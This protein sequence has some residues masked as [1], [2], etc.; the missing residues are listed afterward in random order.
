[1]SKKKKSRNA[2][3]KAARAVATAS[4]DSKETLSELHASEEPG[5]GRLEELEPSNGSADAESKHRVER[6][7]NYASGNSKPVDFKSTESEPNANALA[8]SKRKPSPTPTPAATA[9]PTPKT[10]KK[11]GSGLVYLLFFLSGL[12]SLIYQVVWTRELVLVFGGTTFATSTVLAIFMGG[13][14]LGSYLA[15]RYTDRIERPLRIYGILEG[16]IGGWALIAPILFAAV[17]PVY[18][19]VWQHTHASLLA[20]SLLR[21]AA[22]CLILLVPTTCMGAT[23]PILAK[24]VTSALETVGKQVGRLYALNTFGAICGALLG[25]FILLPQCGLTLATIIAAAINFLLTATAMLQ[26][27]QKQLPNESNELNESD[28]LKE[29]EAAKPSTAPAGNRQDSAAGGTAITSRLSLAAKIVMT[30]FAASGAVAMIYEVCWT[31]ALLMIIGSST[32]AFTVMLSTFLIGIFLGSIVISRYAD[33]AKS[34][35]FWFAILQMTLGVVSLICIR[36]FDRVPFWNL[37]INQHFMRSVTVNMLVRFLLAGVVLIPITTCLGAIFPV[38]VRVCTVSL[39]TVGRSIGTL[40]AANTVGAIVGAFGAGFV[41]LPLF[42][43][44]KTLLWSAFANFLL[45]AALIS[46]SEKRKPLVNIA[47]AVAACGFGAFLYFNPNAWNHNSLIVAQAD[48][49]I[50]RSGTINTKSFEKWQ[51]EQLNTHT[52]VFWKDGSCSNV[53]VLKYGPKTSLLTNGHVDAS[54]GQDTNVQSFVSML[55]LMLK[56]DAKDIAVVGWGSGQTVGASLLFPIRECDAIE[57]EPAVIKASKWFHH[58]NYKAEEDPRVHIEYN[59]GRNF[60]L[61]TN[62]LYDLVISEPSNPWQSGVCNLF[63]REYFHICHK[64][65]K[66]GGMFSLWLQTSEV[67]PED[68]SAVLSAVNKEYPHAVAFLPSLGNIVIWHPTIQSLST[69]TTSRSNLKMQE[70]KKSCGMRTLSLPNRCFH[71]LS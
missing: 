56:P 21:F 44:E 51:Q 3:K 9:R 1:M 50:L 39:A 8:E 5:S 17:T 68:I 28:D 49:R 26:K 70:S 10:Q 45:G 55:P 41:L 7:H 46:V 12:S 31:R 16:I 47:A 38:V 14:A 61:A 24:F 69:S 40:Y 6:P 53:A 27:Q 25:G 18:A 30:A 42:G 19:V 57:L 58:L 34:P 36:L 11:S 13:L 65:L 15:G 22:S 59:D 43:A 62:K 52:V 67:P 37:V 33:K 35:I 60:L 20:L 29:L 4:G 63:T 32:Y 2:E 66:P 23:L 64:R 71:A 54:D 48:R